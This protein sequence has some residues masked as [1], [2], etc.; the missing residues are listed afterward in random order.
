MAKLVCSVMALLTL[1]VAMPIKTEC[2]KKLTT[3]TGT[4][5]STGVLFDQTSDI[6]ANYDTREVPYLMRVCSSGGAL[7]SFRLGLKNGD[8]ASTL[9]GSVGPEGGTCVNS[10]IAQ[11]AAPAGARI[12]YDSTRIQGVEFFYK[13]SSQTVLVGK[14]TGSFT[15]QAFNETQSF[16]GF[17]GFQGSA[18]IEVLGF[19]VQDIAC[20]ETLPSGGT[21]D[22]VYN[23]VNPARTQ[24]ESNMSLLII[25]CI[26]AGVL[27]IFIII[28]SL[29]C[30]KNEEEI[31]SLHVNKVL[32]LNNNV[33]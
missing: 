24:A 20:S 27:I 28:W 7:Q 31:G 22:K 12:W 33:Q 10:N 2:L 9:S 21:G 1:V 29:L 11:T 13:G 8:G 30:C 32:V 6:I 16:L 15:L 14:N 26:V 25:A 17:Y 5:S 4:K 3:L 23:P 18:R 19:L